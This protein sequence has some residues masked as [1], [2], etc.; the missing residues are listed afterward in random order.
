M[1]LVVTGASG[2]VGAHFCLQASGRH[3]LV[4]LHHATALQ[5]PGVAPLRLDLRDPRAAARL[6][7]LKP[8]WIVHFAF[9]VKGEGAAEA[10]RRMMDA[11]LGAEV[12]VAYAS[13]TVVHWARPT[14]YGAARSA[15]EARL[16]AASVPSVILRPSAPYGPRLLSHRPAH[17]ESFETLARLVRWSPVVPLIGDGH[18]RRQPIH[19]RDF[20]EAMLAC[21]AGPSPR[22]AFDAG[23]GSAL[24]FREI[25]AALAAAAGRRPRL[26]PVPKAVF[27]ALARRQP[28]FDPELIDAVDA[29]ELADPGPLEAATGLR[30]R[31][32]AEGAA[33]LL[34]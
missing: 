2:F 3:E 25:I 14:A 32:F 12:P 13:S 26:L 19:V 27:V 9:K 5:L 15:D 8:D 20:A 1:R 18:Y 23:G 29:D 4:G 11:V 24:S 28:N 7:A 6:R 31:P 30:M 22:V 10:N 21:M 34:R 16:R 33:E 17:R